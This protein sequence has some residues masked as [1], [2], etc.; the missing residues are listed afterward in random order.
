MAKKK[1]PLLIGAAI[2]EYNTP[3]SDNNPDG[4]YPKPDYDLNGCKRYRNGKISFVDRVA[5]G[6]SPN[7]GDVNMITANGVSSSKGQ[8]K[9]SEYNWGYGTDGI[10]NKNRDWDGGNLTGM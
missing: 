10:F 1:L 2:G 9:N 4:P 3:V 8:G 6:E 5:D 7:K